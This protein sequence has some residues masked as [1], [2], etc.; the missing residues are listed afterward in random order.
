MTRKPTVRRQ[1]DQAFFKRYYHDA[2]TSVISA[3]DVFKRACFVLAYLAHLQVPVHTVLD[4]G[5]GTGL[6]MQALHDIDHSIDYFGFDPSEYLCRKHGWLQSTVAEFRTRRRFDLVVCQ[7]VMQYMPAAEVERSFAAIARA[8]RGALYFDV[9]TSDDIDDG[10]LDMKR[11]DRKIH[12][13]S[14][15]WYRRRLRKHFVNAGGGVFVMPDARTVLLAL[16]RG[17]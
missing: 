8:C 6:W 4:A 13:R 9:P 2:T 12:V 10:F 3:D 14:A 1:F 16:E 11:T 15:E 5:C 7:D 17:R